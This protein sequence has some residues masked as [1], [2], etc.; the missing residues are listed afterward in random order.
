MGKLPV[1]G[2]FPPEV[3]LRLYNQKF[4]VDMEYLPAG[5]TFSSIAR[6]SSCWTLLASTCQTAPM[7]VFQMPSVFALGDIVKARRVSVS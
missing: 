2:K 4:L 6:R 3:C 1:L 7:S 5:G